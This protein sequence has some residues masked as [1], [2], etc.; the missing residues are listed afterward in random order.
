MFIII[1]SA[2]QITGFAQQTLDLSTLRLA[3]GAENTLP[4]CG[5]KYSEDGIVVNYRFDHVVLAR[6]PLYAPAHT[7]RIDGFWENHE[8][9]RPAT[10]MRWDTFVVPEKGVD[11]TLCDTAYVE[12]PM[13]MSPARPVLWENSDEGYSRKNVLPITEYRGF[14]PS[15][16]IA[17][18]NRNKYRDNHLLEVCV[19][20]VQYDQKNKKVRIYT[21]LGYKVNFD[22][23]KFTREARAAKRSSLS[24]NSFLDNVTLNGRQLSS[25][26]E[27][28]TRNGTSVQLENS[29]YLIISKPKYQEAVD[30]LAEWKRTLGYDVQVAMKSFWRVDTL[31]RRLA[32]IHAS[33]HIDHLLIIG[34][35]NDV[36]GCGSSLYHEHLTDLY[37]GCPDT[38]IYTQS[39]YRGRLPVT[40]LEEANIVVDKIINYE[41]NPC[42]DTAMYRKG[43]HVAYF[44][45]RENEV[46]DSVED[47]RFTLTSERIRNYLMQKGKKVVRVY[48]TE[49]SVW[50]TRWNDS[51]YA[52]GGFLP[53]ELQKSAFAWD[54]NTDSIN[55]YIDQKCFYVLYRGHGG[56]D[57]WKSFDYYEDYLAQLDNGNALPVVFSIT[58]QTGRYDLSDFFCRGF[59]TKKD[60]GCSAIFGASENSKSG[61]NDVLAEGMFDAIWPGTFLWP[62]MPIIPDSNNISTMAPEPT[63]QLGQILD[64][65]LRRVYE[66]FHGT[67]RDGHVKYTYEVFHCFGDP[68]MMMHTETP[69]EFSN[70]SITRTNGIISVDT[71]GETAKI[72]FYNRRT[73][74]IES[75]LGTSCSYT[76]D[77]EISVCISAHNKIPYIDGGTIYIQNKTLTGNDYREARMIKVGNHVT[78]M[79]AQGDVNFTAGD[80]VLVGDEVEIHPG[81][82]VSLGATLEINNR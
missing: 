58:C 30:R 82:T 37:Y 59:L 3:R 18:A 17:S 12:Y 68:S 9:G 49:N 65:G 40:N 15:S 33:S 67:E 69:T 47:R 50:P 57:Q 78:T 38:T 54:G 25:N 76:D 43:L 77:P 20:P 66:A 48:Y 71:G 74:L 55:K 8:V 19:T 79:Q 62:R 27:V 42:I 81:T 72:T 7:V 10:I 35:M 36:P 24:S 13:E 21:R 22:N 41:K 45:D 1:F 29:R 63:Y 75:F 31:F 80:H 44:E 39:A 70:A 2:V 60:G 5:I 4:S 73:K 16:P 52:D 26:E 23:G 53:L 6:D 61:A 51:L 11:V 56:K 46:S 64:Q 34:D 28:D 32:G 14:Y